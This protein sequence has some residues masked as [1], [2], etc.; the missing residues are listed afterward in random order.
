MAPYTLGPEPHLLPPARV[1]ALRSAAA[2]AGI[3][4]SGLHWLLLAPAGLSI[5]A[6]HGP[7]RA[8]TTDVALRLID[9]CAALGGDY[10]VHGSPAQR[11]LAEGREAADRAQ[12]MEFLAAM[13]AAAGQAGIGYCLEPLSPAQTNFVTS[14]AEA[15]AVVAE[16]GVRRRS[17]P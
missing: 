1:A 10:I 2:D 13:A 4:V 16:I 8:A 3:A 7:T 12:A 6:A 9:L 5:T 14:L 15:A 17:A 11:R